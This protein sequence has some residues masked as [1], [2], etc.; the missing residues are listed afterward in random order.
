[1]GKNMTL[2]LIMTTVLVM[3]VF[4]LVG[5]FAE[6]AG[7]DSI[8]GQAVAR[9]GFSVSKSELTTSS[10]IVDSE[11][12]SETVNF[13]FEMEL[14]IE[15]SISASVLSSVPFNDLDYASVGKDGTTLYFEDGSS[16]SLPE[17]HP[18]SSLTATE[19]EAVFDNFIEAKNSYLN[20]HRAISMVESDDGVVV[21][22]EAFTN[23]YLDTLAGN[24]WENLADTIN[25]D[26]LMG[27]AYGSGYGDKLNMDIANSLTD[28]DSAIA[29]MFTRSAVGISFSS[30]KSGTGTSSSYGTTTSTDYY[31]ERGSVVGGVTTV[32]HPDGSSDTYSWTDKNGNG[33]YDSG[34]ED[35]D[36]S[37]WQ[38]L[39]DALSITAESEGG[40][41]LS[42]SESDDLMGNLMNEMIANQAEEMRDSYASY[43][44][45]E[46]THSEFESQFTTLLNNY[47][48][49]QGV[50]QNFNFNQVNIR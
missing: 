3:A 42:T 40:Y 15:P 33:K 44:A 25:I 29:D 34:E 48:S 38:K 28:V 41:M 5:L 24:G 30:Y 1:M 19:V 43:L 39:K 22:S 16:Q 45:G 2:G 4:S 17:G 10:K 18:L 27:G 49:E 11:K 31:S 26:S 13:N 6:T 23:N 50:S 20:S 47:A 21:F 7:E 35:D 36:R 8:A 14:F 32:T 12:E 9:S 37:L 46:I